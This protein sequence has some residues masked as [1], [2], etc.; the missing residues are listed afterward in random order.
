ML[1]L[2]WTTKT[3]ADIVRMGVVNGSPWMSLG[4]LILLVLGL[5]IVGAQMS[6]PFIYT[7]F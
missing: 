4:I 5:V 1:L 3:L 7:L 6:A 2:K